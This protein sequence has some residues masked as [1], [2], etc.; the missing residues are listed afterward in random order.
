[1]QQGGLASISSSLQNANQSLGSAQQQL[2]QAIGGN[3]GMPSPLGGIMGAMPSPRR[4]MLG[5]KTM[6]EVVGNPMGTIGAIQR[7]IGA[8]VGMAAGGAA[9]PDLTGDGQVTQADILK[10]RGVQMQM[11]GEPMMAEQAAMMQAQMPQAPMPQDPS[12]DGALAE[13][14]KMGINPSDVEGLLGQVSEGVGNLDDAE[15]FEQVIN[16]MRGDEAS[17]SERYGE[18]AELVGE[19]DAK[20]TPE[21]VLTLVQPI[22]QIAQI[23]QG[24][25]GLAQEE[26]QAPV[27]GNMAGGIMSTV[28]MGEEVPAPVNFNQGGPVVAMAPGGAVPNNL[29]GGEL[30]NF[31]RDRQA[32][33]QTVGGSDA[34]RQSEFDEQKNLTKSQMLFDIARGALAFATPGDRQMSAAERLAEVAQP[35]IGNIGARA[36]E[37]QK[38]KQGQKAEERA[39]NLQALSS[40]ENA[41]EAQKARDANAAAAEAERNWKTTEKALDRAFEFQKIDK[42]FAFTRGE[43]ETERSFQERMTDRKLAMQQTLLELQG[44]QDERAI[45]MR[46]QLQSELAQLNNAFKASLQQSQFDFTTKERLGVQEYQ[47]NVLD[48]RFANDKAILA[49]QNDN[50]TA[51]IELRAKLQN[52]NDTLKNEWLV[53][54]KKLEFSNTLERD[55]INNANDIAKMELG[56]EYNV[57]LTNLRGSLEKESR[58]STQAFQAAE[59]VLNRQADKDR[60]MSDQEFKEL[61]A[62]ELR[63]FTK[64]EAEIDRQ[65]AA[66]QR[67]IENNFTAAA[68]AR[69]EKVLTIQDR[70]QILDEAYKLGQLAL[71]EEAAKITQLGSKSDTAAITYIGNDE[72]L[73]AYANN[74]LG[75]Q[76]KTI[77]EQTVLNYIN[78]DNSKVWDGTKYVFGKPLELAPK[79]EAAIEAG[80][81]EFFKRMKQPG[82]GQIASTSTTGSNGTG[83]GDQTKKAVKLADATAELFNTD[84]SVNLNAEAWSLT[85]TNRFKEGL[86]YRQTIGLSRVIPGIIAGTS[87]GF[88]EVFGGDST[89]E[90]K[91]HK[92]AGKALT[93]YS[94]DLLQFS[95]DV[96]GDRVLKFVQELIEKETEG[97]RPGG[98]FFK[99]D[100]DALGTLESLED[101]LKQAMQTAARKLPEYGGVVGEYTPTQVTNLRDLMDRTKILL[102][103]TLSFKN[104]FMQPV[105]QGNRITGDNQSTSNAK[106]QILQMRK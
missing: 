104:A 9:F 20:A 34:E 57:A 2:Q 67:S 52:E 70:A 19:E 81:P 25:G 43:N 49:L 98:F 51:G 88:A 93:A 39:L 91:R 95:T 26:M 90:A 105:G 55:G 59:A 85:P 3:S 15:D 33:Y 21:S 16:S 65:I 106:S 42:Q 6:A 87:E 23:D 86:P 46:G 35:V 12:M 24:I 64:D 27:E 72:R 92:A 17:I 83:S 38:F 10:G 82:S 41:F 54:A 36:G 74:Q 68:D 84:G 37:L 45:L 80:N 101:T 71:D 79:I 78:P 13:A 99:T 53:A 75:D 7:T 32:L 58:L 69:A 56:Q 96:S 77:F 103:E 11:G 28:N 97:T 48:Q 89:D 50:T 29:L 60:Q 8:P 100:A 62:K 30:G 44:S 4:P 102:N 1:M 94:N 76:E 40:A 47:D 31:Y 61:M 73:N 63:K 14:T 22:V 18:L 66:T 5:D